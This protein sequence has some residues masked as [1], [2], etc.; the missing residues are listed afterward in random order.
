MASATRRAL[1]RAAMNVS[2][3]AECC[4]LIAN[5]PRMA[6]AAK[7]PGIIGTQPTT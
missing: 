2:L 1:S 3:V 7:A 4:A 5:S 6:L